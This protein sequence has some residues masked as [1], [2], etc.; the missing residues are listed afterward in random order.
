MVD[1]ISNE[2]P[3]VVMRGIVKRFPG[4]VV[5]NDMVDFELH[6]GEIHGLLGE[7]GAGKTT[8]MN[9]L[10][11]FYQPDTGSIE[12]FGKPATF[13]S[14]SDAIKHGIGMVHQHFKL[15]SDMT[16]VE[17]IV[18]GLKSPKGILTDL[19]SAEA[20]IS[21]LAEKHGLHVDPRAQIW[22]LA[23]GELQRVEILKALYR[24]AKIL[25]LDEPTSVL[26][27]TEVN[28]FFNS[29]RGLKQ[30]G[31][32]IV[33]ITHKLDEVMDVTDR[34]TVLRKGRK[35]ATQPTQAVNKEKLAHMMVGEEI[36]PIADKTRTGAGEVVLEVRQLSVYDDRGLEAVKGVTFDVRKAEIIGIA[37]VSGNGQRELVQAIVGLRKPSSGSLKFGGKDITGKPPRRMID[38][39]LA[40]VPE[41]R[42]EDASI[43][44]FRLDENMILKDFDKPPICNRLVDRI[45]TL[46]NDKEIT[47][48]GEEAVKQFSIMTTGISAKARSLSGGNLQKLILARELSG[49]PS[50]IVVSQPTR[51]L[52]IAATE[53]VRS[54][55]VQQRNRGAAVLLVDEDLSE[56]ITLSD[57]VAV[58]Y[59]G[60]IVGLLEPGQFNLEE[61]GLLMTGA[62]K[63]SLA[64]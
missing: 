20:R 14:P 44:D 16:V 51:G 8:L 54:I 28:D 40:Y 4:G 19:P 22:Q 43:A 7:N 11:G 17:N 6:A 3:A 15:V 45:P 64:A 56:L 26:A 31:I 62:K 30:S 37:G 21:S 61:I 41:N 57:R 32:S 1:E 59:K 39:G 35:V 34:V 38:L 60:Q 2:P 24:D 55:L 9:I 63:M 23:V 33:L 12:I 52:D 27:P 48:R 49:Q 10:Y 36:P 18:L 29:L 58:M 47:C 25:I 50:L 53:F 13:R 42:I 5:A 46:L